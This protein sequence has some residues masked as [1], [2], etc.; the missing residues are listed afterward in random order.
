[1]PYALAL[2][3]AGLLAGMSDGRVLHSVD[4]GESWADTGIAPGPVL[5]IAANE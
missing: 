1:M 3:A 2:T 5:A 4:G